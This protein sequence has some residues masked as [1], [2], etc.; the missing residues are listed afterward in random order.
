M[1]PFY[2]KDGIQIYCGD[3]REILPT[4]ESVDLVLTDPPYGIGLKEHGRHGYNWEIAGD[5]DSSVGQYVCDWAER[6]GL[7]T[8]CF[9]SPMKPF[10]GKWRQFLVWNKSGAVGG[11]G[12][13]ATC[14]KFSH[15]TIQV[16]RTPKLQG[17]RDESVLYF[18][19][20]QDSFVYHPVEKPLRLIKYL[21]AKVESETILDPFMGSGT[22]LVAAKLLGRKAIGIEIEEKY[23]EIAVKRLEQKVFQWE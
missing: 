18:P 20:G 3:C 8:I 6:F 11:G 16:A 17:S 21:L 4:L 10:T 14:W 2:D 19:I 13:I 23:C 15:E 22:T 12:D 7:P 9:S 1:E 5:S